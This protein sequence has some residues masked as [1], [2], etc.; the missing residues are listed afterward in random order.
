MAR[1]DTIKAVVD[2][3]EAEATAIITFLHNIV[4]IPSFD[5]QIGSVGTAIAERMQLL[6]FDEVR[7]DTMGNVLGRVGNGP[8][9]LLF[10]SHIDTVGVG[11]Q[12]QWEWDPFAGKIENGIL[13]ARG[14][15]DEKGSTPPMIYALATL[16]RLD[17]L[18]GWTLYYFGN[19]EE[20]CDGLA[21]RALVEHEGIQPDMVV[22]G[23]PTRMGIYRGHRGRVEVK[24]TFTGRS[25]HAA[26]PQ[27]G[28]NPLYKAAHFLQGMEQMDREFANDPFLG[29]GTIAPTDLTVKTPSVNAVPDECQL[30][31]DR[32]VTLGETPEM[33][34][35]QLRRLP[36]GNA[37][38]ISIPVWDTPSYTGFVFPVEK[39]FPAWAL[40]ESH[41][42]LQA[43]ITTCRAI[44]GAEPLVGKWNFST[45]GTY[46]MGKA[47]IPAIGFGPGDER[48]AHTVLDQVPLRDVVDAAKFYAVLPLFLNDAE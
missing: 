40:P 27:L 28:D 33:V 15:C 42:L 14:A 2:E 26:M 19:M 48:H 30:Y 12:A 21:P 44:F 8:R 29:P 38:D 22:I 41:P 4:R 46:W 10:D 24:V 36:G 31:I 43:A 25:A 17:L 23:E 34:L 3:I 45:N 39:T 16:K 13:Y 32:R 35:S 6:G 7:F 11:D 9:R 47:G 18:D 1:T 37:A 5:S 20:W